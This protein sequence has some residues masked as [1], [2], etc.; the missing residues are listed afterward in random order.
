M[1]LCPI[2]GGNSAMQSR[3]YSWYN[4]CVYMHYMYTWQ[5][6]PH[7]KECQIEVQNFRRSTVKHVTCESYDP[8]VGYGYGL[9]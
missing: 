4:V 9:L 3:V 7:L 2:F 5:H 6:L 1:T 8:E